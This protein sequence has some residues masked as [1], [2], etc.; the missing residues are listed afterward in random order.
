MGG[1][2]KLLLPYAGTTL[3]AHVAGVALKTGLPVTIALPPDRPMRHAALAGLA[4]QIVAVSGSSAGMGASLA[5]GVAALPETAPVILLLADMPGITAKDLLAFRAD[6]DT[7]PDRILRAT[8]PAGTPGHPVGFPA[9]ARPELLALTGDQGARQV[10]LRN[11]DRLRYLALPD[12]RAVTDIDTPE[13]W[14]K[15]QGRVP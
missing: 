7:C 8:D 5:A 12:R 2:D 1:A 13:D 14:Q 15:W 3:L 10:L 4:V 11:A 6:W 9:W